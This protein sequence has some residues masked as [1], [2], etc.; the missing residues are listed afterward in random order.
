MELD[1]LREGLRQ[2]RSGPGVGYALSG[3]SGTGKSSTIAAAVRGVDGLRV[4]RG[5][6]DPLGTPRPL[7]PFRE[8]GLPRLGALV[9]AEDV[10]LTETA[11][12]ALTEL[13]S[14]PTVLVIEDLHWA[15]AASADVLRYLV[16]RVETAPLA[17]LLSYRDVEIGPRHPARQLLG[18]FAT[19]DGLR[20]L[21]LAPLSVDGVAAAVDGTGLDPARVHALTGGNPFYVAQVALEPDRPLPTSVRDTVLARLAEIEPEDLEILQ[22]IACSPDRLDDR[23][24][25]MLGVDLEVLRRLGGTT[26][27]THTDEGIAF[28]HE[29]A[30]QAVDS[31]IPP[32]GTPRL[33]QRLLTSLE[34][35]EPLDPATLTHHAQAARDSVRTVT[36]ARAAATEA[37]AAASNT[38]AAAFLEIALEHLPGSAPP[39]E[40]AGCLMLLAQ[41]LYLTAR[42]GTPPPAPAP[43]SPSGT[44]RAARTASPKHTLRSPSLSTSPAAAAPARVTPT[45]P[46]RSPCGSMLPRRSRACTPTPASWR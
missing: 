6:C 39:A 12:T 4:L 35:V 18:D 17:I 7:G 33:H 43:A 28:R 40:R 21:P 5:H 44:R 20:T 13:G 31:T 24:L 22:L 38:E 29:L 14:E 36:Y 1:V 19:L 27:L 15:D 9:T 41:Q 25:P 3:D 16:R 32:G 2:V 37:L 34:Q 46:A 8:L 42:L 23:V 45:R 26:L 10:R 11:E 30:R